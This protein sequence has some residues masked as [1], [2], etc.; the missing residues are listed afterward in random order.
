MYRTSKLL[1]PIA[2]MYA[3]LLIVSNILA[4][5]ITIVWGMPIAAGIVC[6]PLAYL[7]N[8]V[9]TEVYG[10][11]VAKRIIWMGFA[12]LFF[13]V[14]MIYVANILPAA[15]FWKEQ[16]V[17]YDGEEKQ[18][19]MNYAFHAVLGVAPRIAFASLCAFLVGS[20]LNSIV[21]SKL[22]VK[23]NGRFLW[24]RTIGSTI[25]GES[26]DSIVFAFVAFYG[27][28]DWTIEKILALAWTGFLL[29]TLYEVIAT[30]LTY[31]IVSAVKKVEKV[32]V[33]DYSISYNPIKFSDET[34]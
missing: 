8:D 2:M 20:F 32:D 23:T 30:P 6:F 5:K 26:A 12:L 9:L 34:A 7:V 28:S 29:K 3:V 31:A 13:S 17:V 27:H 4:S 22:K 21:L 24:I 16:Q 25:V 11:D 15:D 1:L 18:V 14:V 10:Y 33:Y 19:D